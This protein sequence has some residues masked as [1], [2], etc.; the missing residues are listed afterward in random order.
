MLKIWK[1]K[2]RGSD[3]SELVRQQVTDLSLFENVP[4]WE[5]REHAHDIL[6]VSWSEN[7]SLSG[8]SRYILSCSFDFKVILWDL[9]AEGNHMHQIFEHRE[10]PSQ[11]TFNP[12][13]NDV[14]VSV[15]LDQVVRLF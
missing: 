13:Y 6:D 3:I 10:V 4:K 5:L 8:T 14:F 9:Q 7:P 15:S 2:K 1:V 12:K 11:V